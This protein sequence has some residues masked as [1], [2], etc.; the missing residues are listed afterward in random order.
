MQIKK[1]VSFLIAV[2]WLGAMQIASAALT[3]EITQGVDSALPIAVVPFDTA[4]LSSKL[5]VDLAA[6]ASVA[7]GAG[8]YI[9]RSGATF[10]ENLISENSNES[11]E[12]GGIYARTSAISMTNSLIVRNS[13]AMSTMRASSIVTSP[14]MFSTPMRLPLSSVNVTVS[15]Y[16]PVEMLPPP[17]PPSIVL[18]QAA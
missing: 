12:G 3:I 1:Q 4:K 8:L 2:V 11:G 17:H 15:A 14:T 5:P 9:V 13:I 18:P 16:R 7:D 6:I 10:A